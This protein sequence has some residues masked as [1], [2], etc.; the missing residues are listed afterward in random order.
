MG[1]LFH[2]FKQNSAWGSFLK[3]FR[4][5]IIDNVYYIPKYPEF[6]PNN[7]TI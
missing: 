2:P 5:A 3:E 7:S 6:E 4:T 1:V